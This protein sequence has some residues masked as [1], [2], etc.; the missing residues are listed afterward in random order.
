MYKA[1]EDIFNLNHK[2]KLTNKD[3]NDVKIKNI[4]DHDIPVVDL[5]VK[6]LVECIK[7]VKAKKNKTTKDRSVKKTKDKLVKKIKDKLVKKTSRKKINNKKVQ[8][9]SNF[10]M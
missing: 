9:S 1:S 8:L 7:N 10:D 3:I 5:I 4:P 6:R 2:I